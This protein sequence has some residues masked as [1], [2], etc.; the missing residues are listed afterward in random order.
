MG[1]G[2]ACAL[3]SA[4]TWSYGVILYTRLGANVPPLAL[5]FFKNLLV[6]LMVIPLV[7]IVERLTWPDFTTTQVLVSLASGF[8]GIAVAD[9]FYFKALN[10]LGAGRMGIVGNLYSPFVLVLSFLFLAERLSGTQV[11]GF[12][13]VTGGVFIISRARTAEAVDRRALAR[14]V[15]YGVLAVFL[16][17]GAIV[18]VKRVL[19][20]QPLMPVVALR[21]AGGVGGLAIVF[22]AMQLRER[23]AGA[24]T[25]MTTRFAM[26]VPGRAHWR[27]LLLAA[28]VGQLVSMVLWLAGYKFTSASVAAILNE[29]ASVFIV[30]LAWW[31]LGE[32]MTR[33][34]LVGVACTLAGVACMLL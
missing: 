12:V 20:A 27:G 25:A 21:L 32:P 7:A 33:R 13:L 17:A 19:E 2:E 16:M 6:F 9:T 34:K 26:P 3:L 30:L 5:N 23:V 4:A 22:F 24:A 14:G 18:M 11:A 15:A 1:I 31:L 10:A 29:T 28:F 8:I